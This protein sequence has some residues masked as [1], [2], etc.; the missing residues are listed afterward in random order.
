MNVVSTFQTNNGHNNFRWQKNKNFKLFEYLFQTILK[1]QTEMRESMKKIFPHMSHERKIANIQKHNA[2][3]K[4]PLDDVLVIFRRK[5]V[6][7]Q[8]QAPAKDNH[9]TSHLI[10]IRKP[11]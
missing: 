8:L 3:I 11:Y 5:H 4:R 1:T 2:R 7:P 6:R 10:L 9:K